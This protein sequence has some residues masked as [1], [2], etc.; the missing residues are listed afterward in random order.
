MPS[1]KKDAPALSQGSP[2]LKKDIL[3]L[4][5][6]VDISHMKPMG[7]LL[8]DY[9]YMSTPANAQGVYSYLTGDS[10]PQMPLNGPFWSQQQLQLFNNWMASGYQP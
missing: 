9:D 3:P 4:F 7:V 6:P 10:Q 1:K 5:R 8:N 2:S